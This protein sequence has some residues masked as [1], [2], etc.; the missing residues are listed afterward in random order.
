MCIAQQFPTEGG[1]NVTAHDRAARGFS[2][3]QNRTLDAAI[4]RSPAAEERVSAI[5]GAT[6]TVTALSASRGVRRL[7]VGPLTCC[8]VV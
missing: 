3:F 7:W 1:P 2:E 8:S 4:W 6:R 5:G